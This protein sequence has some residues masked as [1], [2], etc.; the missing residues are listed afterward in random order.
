MSEKRSDRIMSKKQ[1]IKLLQELNSADAGPAWANFIDRFAPLIMQTVRQ[2][3]YEHDRSSEC[4]LFVCEKL[5]EKDFRRLLSFNPNDRCFFTTWLSTVMFNLCV[6]W[7]RKEFG[8]V[9]M[10]PAISAL[11]TFDQAVFRH[12]YERRL[13]MDTCFLLLK[14]EFP[15]LTRQ[16]LANAVSRVHKVLTPRQRWRMSLGIRGKKWAA[17]SD[18]A[19]EPDELPGP[20]PWPESEVHD[21]QELASLERALNLLPA[22]QR[23]LIRL[24]F[25]QGLTLK[26][27]A[28]LTQLGDPFRARR[29]I[30]AAL[31]ALAEM[32]RQENFSEKR[33]N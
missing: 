30:Q 15:D 6:D 7:H 29:H 25:Q 9:S 33:K 19:V 8:R 2:F 31:K 28:R 21:Q 26:E 14:E 4:F 20:E 17:G 23:F 18:H 32:M 5:I 11:P 24:R 16:Q 13:A 27:V 22:N 10:L 3:E 1:V 12:R